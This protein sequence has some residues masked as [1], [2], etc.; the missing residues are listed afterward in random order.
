[1][2][3]FVIWAGYLFS[4]GKLPG[5]SFPV[6]A[7]ELFDGIGSVIR[8]NSQGHLAYLFGRVSQTGWWYYFPVLLGLKTPIAA[9]LLIVAGAWCCW[10]RRTTAALSPLAFALGVL[11]PAIWG[12]INIGVRHILPVYL[13]F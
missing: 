13:A 2:G 9:L 7:P 3:A 11:L 6:P 1:M 5:G 8:H 4:F 12:N 10:R